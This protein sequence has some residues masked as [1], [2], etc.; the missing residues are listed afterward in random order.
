[1]LCIT[2]I[3]TGCGCNCENDRYELITVTKHH[4]LDP[5]FN[6]GRSGYD[7]VVVYRVDKIEGTKTL[8]KDKE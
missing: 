8:V 3:L 6:K 5:D 4:I 7:E 2:Y 1:M